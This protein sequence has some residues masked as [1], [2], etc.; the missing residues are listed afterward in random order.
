MF[1]HH[2]EDSAPAFCAESSGADSVD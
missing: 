2:P 1:N